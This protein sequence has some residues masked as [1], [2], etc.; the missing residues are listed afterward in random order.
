MFLNS[1]TFCGVLSVKGTSVLSPL[2]PIGLLLGLAFAIWLK[3]PTEVFQQH[4]V[5]Y[6]MSFG[7]AAC[8]ITNKLVV[9]ITIM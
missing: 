7:M 8:K 2:G 1:P 3:S 9:S 4:L 6:I 5:L